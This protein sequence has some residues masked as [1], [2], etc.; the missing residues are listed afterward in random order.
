MLKA[1]FPY[2]GGK[3]RVAH[4]VWEYFHDVTN[5]I[6]PFGGSLAVL[7][8]R[9]KVVG[10][11]IIN[12]IDGNVIN[13]WRAIKYD[14]DEVAKYANFP[15]SQCDYLARHIWL[16]KTMEDRILR[17][18]GNPE[19]YD[20]RA[21]G[22]WVY[23]MS[24]N[25]GGPVCEG[26]GS[27]TSDDEGKLIKSPDGRGIYNRRIALGKPNGMH[28]RSIFKGDYN[29]V[30]TNLESLKAY[31]KEL[32]E[33][34]RFVKIA[35]SD[36]RALMK[37]VLIIQDKITGYFLDPP[38][39]NKLRDEGVYVYDSVNTDEIREWCIKHGEMK[40]VRII[41]CGYE[42]EY[43]MPDNWKV[44]P[45]VAGRCYARSNPTKNKNNRFK[46]RLW[47]SPHC[48]KKEVQISIEQKV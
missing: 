39:N 19:Y 16:V 30:D 47:I 33:R 8:N 37:D 6:E 29:G 35:C 4:I 40:N 34:L 14:P 48:K 31:F 45:W 17:I 28:R 27:I 3:S 32:S 22:Y 41:L 7:L 11:E 2:P 23:V 15:I 42:S 46:E 10:E 44:V 20:P 25:F 38:Y 21:A 1:P 18:K 26:K 13:F 36:Y 5:Y 12:D 43:E 24:C 9:P